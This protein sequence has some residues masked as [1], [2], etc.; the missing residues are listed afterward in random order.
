MKQK[1]LTS[2]TYEVWTEEDREIGETDEKGFEREEELGTLRD[3]IDL[4][5][6]Y[7]ILARSKGDGTSWWSSEAHEDYRTGQDT[8][9]SLHVQYADGKSLSAADFAKINTIIKDDYDL[10][11]YYERMSEK[12]SKKYLPKMRSFIKAVCKAAKGSGFVCTEITD[13]S[14]DTYGVGV[15]IYPKGKTVEDGVDVT[16]DM[17]ESA[18]AGDEPGGLNFRVNIVGYDGV[19]VGGLT[20]Y[21]YT[22]DVWVAMDDDKAVAERWSVFD[23]SA[24][25]VEVVSLAKGWMQSKPGSMRKIKNRVLR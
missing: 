16:V 12:L 18:V 25:P 7:D 19:V 6:R 14:D 22:Q 24:D 20:P 21:N 9:Y 1:Y 8:Y 2:V 4:A 23:T 5:Q 10:A 13:V 11:G 3:V 17:P 15:V